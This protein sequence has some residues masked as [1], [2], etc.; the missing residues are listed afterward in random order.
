MKIYFLFWLTAYITNFLKSFGIRVLTIN[1]LDGILLRLHNH[2]RSGVLVE[3]FK[4]NK[5]SS[6]LILEWE[7]K[8]MSFIFRLCKWGTWI[9]FNWL[10][11]TYYR[12]LTSKS[13]YALYLRLLLLVL[14]LLSLLTLLLVLACQH[15]QGTSFKLLPTT[16]FIIYG[17]SV[18]AGFAEQLPEQ[19]QVGIH[20]SWLQF[21][22][23]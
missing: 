10:F 6:I 12:F 15:H 3:H 9:T 16:L 21:Q 23:W 14:L 17:K 5:Y 7:M 22:F 19:I 13:Y 4:T 20:K 8:R 1:K 18:P 2:T 11:L